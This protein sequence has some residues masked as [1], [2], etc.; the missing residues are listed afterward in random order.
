MHAPGDRDIH[1]GEDHQC[2]QGEQDRLSTP[3]A[4]ARTLSLLSRRWMAASDGT[5]AEGGATASEDLMDQEIDEPVL[6][7][8]SVK[9]GLFQMEILKG[10]TKTKL[11]KSTHVMVAPLKAGKVQQSGAWPLPPGLHVLHTYTKLKMGS[12]KVSMVVRNMSDSPIYLKKGMQIVW[13]ILARLV[14]LAKL[15]LEMEATLGAEV[16]QEPMSACTPGEASGE[17]ES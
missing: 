11:G 4:I 5:L 12:N 17:A 15:S 2:H 8:E 10:N 3:W 1:P 9:L 6:M 14:P 13:V 7:W 16:Q